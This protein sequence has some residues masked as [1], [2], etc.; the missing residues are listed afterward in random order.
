LELDWLPANNIQAANRLI[1]L[2]KDE[3][4]TFDICTR[5]GTVDDHIQRIL[6]RR[7]QELAT[8]I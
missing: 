1:S 3:P 8:M 4:V 6:L 7:A 2:D 5:P